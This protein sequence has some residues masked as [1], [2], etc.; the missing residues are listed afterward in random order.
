MSQYIPFVRVSTKQQETARQLADIA[1]YA[2]AQGWQLAAPVQE[3]VSGGKK[4]RERP[5]LDELHKRARRGD[6]VIATEI[7]RLGRD[8][9]Q[10]LALIEELSERGV[11]MFVLNHRLATLR[12]D[13]SRDAMAQA[14]LTFGAEFARLE[15]V[16]LRERVQSGVDYARSQGR[17]GGR[18]VGFTKDDAQ[19]LLDHA[20]VVAR[21]LDGQSIRD[22]VALT[23]KADKTVSKVRKMLVDTGRMPGTVPRSLPT[24]DQL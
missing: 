15:R 23:K 1:T 10:V 17:I 7:S 5:A 20:D 14:M 9:A 18:R 3:V 6:T 2:S 11:C 13:G 22:T 12:A 8:T 4:N 16:T 19:F 24:P 21:L